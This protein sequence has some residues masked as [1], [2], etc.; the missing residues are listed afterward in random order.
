MRK[1][2]T[3]ILSVLLFVSLASAAVITIVFG[4]G[5][6]YL[7]ETHIGEVGAANTG[8]YYWISTT[9]AD[10][11][12]TNPA[13]ATA[14]LD[15]NESGLLQFRAN[16]IVGECDWFGVIKTATPTNV[17]GKI[18]VASL[19]GQGVSDDQFL[20]LSLRPTIRGVGSCQMDYDAN[21]T[22]A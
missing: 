3:T 10:N 15:F 7:N 9:N 6:T 13:E 14:S 12:S 4:S 2:V 18:A 17:D 21:I 5:L 19:D 20:Y 11:F 1:K 8:T 22:T 16:H